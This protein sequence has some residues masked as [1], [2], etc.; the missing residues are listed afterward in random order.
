MQNSLRKY[1]A[2]FFQAL[3][4][5]TRIA[6]VEVLREGE[7]S[8]G[9][10]CEQIDVEQATVSQHLAILK[11]R[12]VVENR[13]EGNQV[14][15]RLRDPLLGQVL[16]VMRKFFHTHLKEAMAILNDMEEENKQS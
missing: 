14:F 5:P 8:V 15:Y 6:I 9:G 12:G 2:A 1:K 4:H 13:K 3:G 10:L 16:D 7:V 11:A